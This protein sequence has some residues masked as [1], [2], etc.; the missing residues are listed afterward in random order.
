[1]NQPGKHDDYSLELN[2]VPGVGN[3]T[4]NQYVIFFSTTNNSISS[5]IA[6]DFSGPN[7]GQISVSNDKAGYQN[8]TNYYPNGTIT[9][10]IISGIP[11]KMNF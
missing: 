2:N 9:E 5:G 1:M 4:K 11:A 3:F 10:A 7:I 8:Q 6:F